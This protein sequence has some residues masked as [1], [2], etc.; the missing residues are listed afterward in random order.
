MKES[1][2]GM[3]PPGDSFIYNIKTCGVFGKLCLPRRVGAQAVPGKMTC[4][5]CRTK[6]G[7]TGI[8]SAL[9]KIPVLFHLRQLGQGY[10]QPTVVK[11]G[12]STSYYYEYA[13]SI[14]SNRLSA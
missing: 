8:S 14:C 5:I 2:G 10:R 4:G 3:L 6:L 1:P 12:E 11:A 13:A 7:N 9:L